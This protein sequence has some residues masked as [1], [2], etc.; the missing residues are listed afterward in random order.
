M[1]CIGSVRRQMADI[2][3]LQ[4]DI[5]IYTFH[6][7]EQNAELYLMPGYFAFGPNKTNE[8]ICLVYWLI[9]LFDFTKWFLKSEF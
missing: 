8:F 2:F 3:L 7:I 5:Y 9:W 6:S 4:R 1:K